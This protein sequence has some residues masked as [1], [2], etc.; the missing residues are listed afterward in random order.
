MSFVIK[1][2][3]FSLIELLLTLA[4][5]VIVFTITIPRLS[6]FN[7]FILDNEVDKLF[8]VFSYLQQKAIA[9]NQPQEVFFDLKENSYSYNLKDNNQST[10]CHPEL[11]S[12]S[13]PSCK[14]PEVIKF[15]FLSGT[16]GPPSSPSSPISSA[17]TFKN[18]GDNLYKA[19]FYA[20]GKIQPGTVYLVDKDQK[21]MMALTCPISQV[22]CIRKYRY[23]SGKWICLR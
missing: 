19:L 1:K 18:V 11:V 17:V 22:S 23:D 13:T 16:K 5:V 6:F 7:R 21:F 4:I 9:T 2:S 8:T 20:D 15:G 3:S 14:L 12:G 10:I